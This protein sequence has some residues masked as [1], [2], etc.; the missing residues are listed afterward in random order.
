VPPRSIQ[1]SQAAFAIV[2]VLRPRSA[3]GYASSYISSTNR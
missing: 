1:K 3:G 2:V